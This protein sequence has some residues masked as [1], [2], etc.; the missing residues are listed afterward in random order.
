M[1]FKCHP[2]H[3]TPER[4]TLRFQLQ[5]KKVFLAPNTCLNKKAGV[6]KPLIY[7]LFTKLR[8]FH[9]F[10]LQNSNKNIRHFADSEVTPERAWVAKCEIN[11]VTKAKLV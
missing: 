4:I 2:L 11:T 7:N 9:N 1:I 10:F 8:N 3:L 5:I 6:I